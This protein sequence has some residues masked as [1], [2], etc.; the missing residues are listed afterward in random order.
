MVSGHYYLNVHG[1][2]PEI[3]APEYL[4]DFEAAAQ[5]FLLIPVVSI[6]WH[7]LISSP[8]ARA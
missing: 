5:P 6:C 8:P 4:P 2:L 7:S 3:T 1:A